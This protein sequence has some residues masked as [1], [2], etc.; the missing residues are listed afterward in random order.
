VPPLASCFSEFI[1]FLI[2]ASN[3]TI[4]AETHAALPAPAGATVDLDNTHN[5]LRPTYTASLVL[6]MLFPALAVPMRFYTKIFIIKMYKATD[7]FC[8]IGFVSGGS[9]S[10]EVVN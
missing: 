10:H 2:S 4:M 7:L 3:V 8:L 1:G 9:M 5:P 6:I